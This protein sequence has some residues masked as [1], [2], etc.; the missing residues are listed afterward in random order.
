MGEARPG[1]PE[2]ARESGAD[3]FKKRSGSRRFLKPALALI[4][5]LLV[6]G[7]F[8][9][10][11]AT[12]AQKED[13]KKDK[14]T[15]VLE[16]TAADVARVERRELSRTVSI[17]GSVAPLIQSTVRAKVPGEVRR[18]LA[19]EGERVAENQVIATLDTSD[20]QARLD[21]QVAA[22]EE[23]KARL[24]IAR[25]NRENN[26]QL[27]RQKFISQNAFDTTDSTFEASAASVRSADAQ[28]RL[29]RKAMDDAVVRSPIAGIVARRMVNAG[30]KVS[31]DS[32]L[33]TV[34]DL[35]HM[36]V[37][38]PAPATEVPNVRPGQPATFRVDGFGERSFE[39]RVE[40]IN[41]AADPGSRSI[42]LYVSIPNRDGA[43]KGGMFAKGQVVVDRSPPTLVVPASALRE[44]A[45]QAYV[46]TIENGKI[47]R[48]AVSVG[49]RDPQS[50]AVEIRSGLEAGL[51]VVSARI[52]GLK[53]GSPA[54]LKAAKAA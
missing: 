40:R 3:M 7:T 24:D 19:R 13:P 44:E 47:A 23:G 41:P 2:P 42:M 34:V 27:L 29:A 37:E 54:V 16:F 14:D 21:G 49:L 5:V 33:F 53:P 1:D 52:S 17:S 22:L 6:G 48:R 30:E 10:L 51:T 28:V 15:V 50:A 39:G 9:G 12:Q 32:P 36:E 18:V 31:V 11:R 26:L 38:A 45:G 25:K 35:T 8:L 4:A 46:Y 43:L 20:L